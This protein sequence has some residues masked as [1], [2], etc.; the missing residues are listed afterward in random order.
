MLLR[1]L[2]EARLI[3]QMLQTGRSRRGDA[4]EARK[5]FD[6]LP[7]WRCRSI[8]ILSSNLKPR[9]FIVNRHG[10]TKNARANNIHTYLCNVMFICMVVMY[11]N[12]GISMQRTIFNTH[13]PVTPPS[14]PLPFE[15]AGRG[16][17]K[18]C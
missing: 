1:T 15:E 4:G 9:L 13:T 10:S 18:S 8:K 14:S 7:R 2:H 11:G 5:P 16:G 17:V 12:I 6:N 3:R